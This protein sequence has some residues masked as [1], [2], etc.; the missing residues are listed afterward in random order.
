M[1][2]LALSYPDTV[3]GVSYNGIRFNA[4]ANTEAFSAR[5]VPDASGRTIKHVD[6]SIT[7]SFW[8]DASAD[9][10]RAVDRTITALLQIA[11]PFVY[12][13]RGVGRVTVNAGGKYDVKYGP[14]PQECR[15]VSRGPNQKVKLIWTVSW[16]SVAC[17]D[18]VTAGSYPY[19]FVWS[20]RY[21]IDGAGLTTRTISGFVSVPATRIAPKVRRLPITADEM[22][23]RIA[24]ALPT[25]FRRES[26][27][28]DLD[29]AK[30]KLT[31]SFT[32][33]E[34]PGNY[35][36]PGVIDGSLS[37]TLRQEPAKPFL[38]FATISCDYELARGQPASAA[39]EPFRA[40]VAREKQAI[41]NGGGA[42]GGAIGVGGPAGGKANP[43]VFPWAFEMSNPNYHGKPV[44]RMSCVLKI[45]SAS[46]P[47]LLAR[48]GMWQPLPNQ[49][50]SFVAP[51]ANHWG[52][53][54]TRGLV[55]RA[56][57]DS[58]VDLCRPA[59]PVIS[60]D[61]RGGVAL[62]GNIVGFTPLTAGAF[63]A[64]KPG[65]A[66]ATAIGATNA[67]ATVPIV[68][69]LKGG[70]NPFGAK[71]K[72]FDDLAK[73]PAAGESWVDYAC[74]YRIESDDAV[75]VASTL[76]SSPLTDQTRST[77]RFDVMNGELPGGRETSFYP[78]ATDVAPT[79]STVSGG[80][81]FS[82]RKSKP[83]VFVYITGYAKRI[84]HPVPVPEL[85]EVGGQSV[86]PCN[87]TGAGEGFEQTVAGADAFG[88]PQYVAKWNL[89]YCVENAPSKAMVAIP[90]PLVNAV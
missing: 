75:L 14:I 39:W 61:L 38:W 63:V 60:A 52:V 40:L 54:G 56:A 36:P 9:A 3:Q 71:V 51:L 64:G 32:D 12:E 65:G 13:G 85:L 20:A 76:P 34:L 31:F 67:G 15:I 68:T 83:T 86:T 35:F 55:L 6:Y 16:S 2:A 73:A 29:Y 48:S 19:E 8:L 11:A 18:A 53:R 87:R 89:R 26:Q 28:F 84:G 62:G 37:Y 46:F 72:G 49:W 10:G 33:R 21:D 22:R 78:P 4:S 81:T 7:I 80:A 59:E 27:S 50:G 1:A 69:E 47:Q 5:P 25:G 44:V 43:G 82:Q 79:G 24:P 57:D 42:L 74:S 17:S 88:N 23:E 77:G 30:T 66:V 70:P 41:T 90:N 58:I 45:V